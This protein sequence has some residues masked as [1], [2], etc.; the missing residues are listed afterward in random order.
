MT[1][2]P[3]RPSVAL[4]LDEAHRRLVPALLDGPRSNT[5]DDIVGLGFTPG[6]EHVFV[7]SVDAH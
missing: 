2:R 7:E 6:D 5:L 4:G 1:H 3:A